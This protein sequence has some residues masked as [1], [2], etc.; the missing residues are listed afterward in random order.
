MQVQVAHVTLHERQ[1]QIVLQV[2]VRTASGEADCP[3]ALTLMSSSNGSIFFFPLSWSNNL[4]LLERGAP[5]QS[6]AQVSVPL[7]Q[8]FL[9]LAPVPL[10]RKSLK[11][12]ARPGRWR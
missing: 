10:R 2:I 1:V 6:I 5:C 11:G 8:R 7:T 9:L 12:R 3:F 4:L